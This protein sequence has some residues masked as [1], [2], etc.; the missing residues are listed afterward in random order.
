MTKTSA[1]LPFTIITFFAAVCGTAIAGS[2]E[3]ETTKTL[4]LDAKDLDKFEIDA[5]AGFLKIE[6]EEGRDSIEV[7][8]EIAVEDEDYRLSLDRK[9]SKAVLIA[10]PN[11]SNTNNWF[12]D[13]PKI[14]LT[15]KMPKALVLQIE[16]GSGFIELENLTGDLRIDD[17]S[18]HINATKIAANV[19]I[20][21]GSGHIKLSDITGSIKIHDGSGS[22]E[23]NGAGESVDIKDGSGGIELFDIGGKVDVEDGSGGLVVKSAKG[24]VTIDDGSGD[25]RVESLAAGLTVIEAGSG[26]LSMKNVEGEI[27]TH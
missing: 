13:S 9:G 21:D 6:G 19:N 22:I 11:P 10:D 4:S 15:I 27:I 26:G 8:A 7:V 14:D 1:I 25:I 24:H 18:G 5:R 3:Y 20:E 23:I 12:G 16:D 17:G 2:I